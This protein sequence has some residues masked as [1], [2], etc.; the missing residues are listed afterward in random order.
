MTIQET[1]GH[2]DPSEVEAAMMV[3]TGLASPLD[4]WKLTHPWRHGKYVSVVCD[5]PE[6]YMDSDGCVSFYGG[7]PIAAAIRTPI[8]DY[9]IE[10]HNAKLASFDPDAARREDHA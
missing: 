1:S 10:L 6:G 4:Q 2:T 3:S 5:V 8:A 7:L 9:L